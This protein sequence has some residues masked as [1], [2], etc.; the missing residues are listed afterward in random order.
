VFVSVCVKCG[1]TW[2]L[3]T[4]HHARARGKP[5]P[6]DD[7]HT[8]VRWPD[9]VHYPG[10][11]MEERIELLKKM[12]AIYPFSIYKTHFAPPTIKLRN[13]SFYIVGVRNP[14]DAVASL[15]PFLRNHNP[16]FAKIWGGF[17]VEAGKPPGPNE[18]KTYE[19]M[20]LHDIGNG[21][22][23]LDFFITDLV[24][25]WW[26]YRKHKNVLFVHYSDRLKDHKGEIDRMARFV[27]VNLTADELD[28]VAEQ[29]SFETMKNS[30]SKYNPHAIFDEYKANGKLPRDLG[31]WMKDLVNLGGKRN[32]K[33]ELSPEFIEKMVAKLNS[34]FPPE[35]VT[36]LLHGGH[37]VPDVELRP[38]RPYET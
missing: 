13:D 26:P 7:I 37:E 22:P 4:M 30:S 29:T 17:P 18:D 35:V 28:A 21:V 12:H 8:E 5:A 9:L 23:M 31:G 38:K 16:N 14:L 25:S 3:A 6:Y 19:Y 34:D 20:I 36:W 32:A 24:H 11:S 10:Q 1:T 2:A 27:G 15:K 33:S